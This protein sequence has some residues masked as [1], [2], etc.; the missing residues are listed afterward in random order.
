MRTPINLIGP[1]FSAFLLTLSFP[2]WNLWILGF[3]CF[4]PL[5]FSFILT[6]ENKNKI[7]LAFIFGIVHFST[8]LYWLVYTLN[9]YGNLNLILSLFLLLLLSSYLALYYVF[10]FYT[11]FKLKIFESPNF[12]K[13]I[14]FSLTLVGIEYLRGKLLTGF[15]WGQLGYIL[16]NF[17]PF[18]Q[19]ADIWGIWGLSFICALINYYIFFLLYSFYFS[20]GSLL[21]FRFLINNFCFLILF[22][23]FLNY[24]IYKKN[25]WEKII[26]QEKDSIKVSLLQGNIPQ[27]MKEINEIEYS[28]KIYEKLALSALKEKPQI[29]FFPETS[30][31]F[32]F[33]HE[34]EP[35]LKLLAFLDKITLESEKFNYLPVLIFGTFRLKY[36]NGD[37]LVYNSLIVWDEKDFVDL[38][39]KEKLV[40]F[41]E[42]VPL[43]KYLS[44]LRRIT[45]GLGI[46]KPGFSK[47]LS[48][49]LK[50]KIIKVTPLI[51][52]ESAFS[53]ILRKRLEENP[54]LIFIATND[55][56]F[57]KTSAPYQHFQMAIVRAV[58]ARRYT[59]QVANTGITGIIDPTGK[60]IKMTQ[61]EK[62][63]IV[64]GEIK[65]FYERTLFIKYGNTLGILGSSI[66]LLSFILTLFPAKFL[67]P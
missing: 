7:I 48:F 54:Q 11:N 64:Y 4:V 45:V 25:L 38:Y 24:G 58:E 5:F 15:T 23:T 60:I 29:I 39:D 66:L 46:V 26:S 9:K 1:I 8:L 52:F 44:F 36:K 28:L 63:E 51:C 27:E 34:K 67:N 56:W 42:Y 14:F 57:G 32:F 3:F 16:S 43:E 47:N 41:G 30:F 6:K 19:L 22:I 2:K 17:S 53:E 35:T 65:P 59:V 37:P 62:E 10:F 33:P 49:P 50:D 61:L 20:V 12:I 18:L 55:A 13:G 21:N 31:P 40:P